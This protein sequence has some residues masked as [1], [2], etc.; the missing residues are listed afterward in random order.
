MLSSAL[1]VCVATFQAESTQKEEVGEEEDEHQWL[2]RI[3][4][5]AQSLSA[6]ADELVIS[7]YS[8][9]DPANVRQHANG[10][11]AVGHE[12]IGL[13]DSNPTIQQLERFSRLRNLVE[14]MITKANTDITAQQEARPDTTS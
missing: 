10:L 11:M 8:P 1:T 3:V 4:E 12:V 2:E 13:L 9:Q 6:S 7:L 14:T 5:K